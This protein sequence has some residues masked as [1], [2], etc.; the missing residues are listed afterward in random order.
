[1]ND[2]FFS[3]RGATQGAREAHQTVAL[4]TPRDQTLSGTVL[5][6][7]THI[8]HMPQCEVTGAGFV[9]VRSAK[10]LM[11]ALALDQTADTSGQVINLNTNTAFKCIPHILGYLQF[12]ADGSRALCRCT[13]LFCSLSQFPLGKQSFQYVSGTART[14]TLSH[15]GRTMSQPYSKVFHPAD[16][17]RSHREVYWEFQPSFLSC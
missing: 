10:A 11:T 17:R 6:L 13:L 14:Y 16:P 7:L 4:S 15:Q 8:H 1:M 12:F 2:I 3:L 5:P 9:C